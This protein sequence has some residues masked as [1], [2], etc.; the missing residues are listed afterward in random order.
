MPPRFLP[1]G[2]EILVLGGG[3]RPDGK[4]PSSMNPNQPMRAN[5]GLF[6]RRPAYSHV[7]SSIPLPSESE[8]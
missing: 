5:V 7:W 8:T 3:A 4:P 1:V 2:R 6:S